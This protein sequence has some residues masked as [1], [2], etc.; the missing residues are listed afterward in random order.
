MSRGWSERENKKETGTELAELRSAKR[1][2]DV[3]KKAN[4]EIN[5]KNLPK[6]EL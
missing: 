5:L 1:K 2:N 4:V 3:A 6:T